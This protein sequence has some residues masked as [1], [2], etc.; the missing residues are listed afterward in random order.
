[1]LALK[2]TLIVLANVAHVIQLK[3][4]IVVRFIC[5]LINT[6]KSMLVLRLRGS[7][8]AERLIQRFAPSKGTE[9]QPNIN[10]II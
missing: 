9:L 7:S 10:Q 4:D 6:P 2:G 1:M 8:L 5:F 3:A